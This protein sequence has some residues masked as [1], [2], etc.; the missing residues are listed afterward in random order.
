MFLFLSLSHPVSVA[1]KHS[2]TPNPLYSIR[3]CLHVDSPA[4]SSFPDS[5]HPV[6]PRY[7]ATFPTLLTRTM[8]LKKLKKKK[9]IQK[10]KYNKKSLSSRFLLLGAEKPACSLE[11][12]WRDKC[13][14]HCSV[15]SL[16]DC[17]VSSGSNFHLV[18]FKAVCR[19]EPLTVF[20]PERESLHMQYSLSSDFDWRL[21]SVLR[22]YVS[23]L[24]L[25]FVWHPGQ[26]F[27]ASLNVC[28][29][30]DHLW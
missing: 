27:L 3:T 9:K 5:R 12:G 8:D 30:L 22:L 4:P 28:K 2:I 26:T 19:D 17:L 10:K 24:L 21:W 7:D 15:K 29:P 6:H 11:K 25:P 20:I 14:A 16:T 18:L 13:A 23:T 1:L